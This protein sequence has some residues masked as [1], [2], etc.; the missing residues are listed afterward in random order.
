L[1]TQA[2]FETAILKIIF[3]G[4]TISSSWGNG[5]ATPCRAILRSLHA[6]GHQVAFYEKELDYYARRRDFASCSYCN[7][8]LYPEWGQIREQAL[9]DI[10]SADVVIVTS[11]CPEGARISDELLNLHRPLRVFYDLDTPITLE[12]LRHDGVDY[13]RADQIAE[14]DLY[15]S[16]AGGPILGELKQDWGARCARA[17]FGCVEPSLY[18]RVPPR[19]SF[20]SQLSYMGTYSPDRQAKVEALF[21]EPARSQTQSKFLLAG[22][23]Y[24]AGVSWPENVRLLEHIAPADH[25]A[26]YSSSRL[27]LNLTRSGMARYGFCPSGRFFEAAACGTPLVSDSFPGLGSFFVPD[28]EL[29]LVHDA[30]GVVQAMACSDEE[31]ARMAVRARE[32]TLSEH[33]GD[34]R[35]RQLVAFCEEARGATH[36]NEVKD[37]A[38]MIPELPGLPESD[39]VSDPSTLTGGAS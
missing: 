8:V 24:P 15:L 34:R 17:L 38:R 26:L 35:A 30:H 18:R 27:T 14:F 16:F 25:P 20:Q 13:L 22:S 10:A 2:E 11:Y 31:L 39:R 5:H 19:P 9:R 1:R 6:L 37:R 12:N 28:E 23:M 32:R 3:L 21:L 33:S 36:G 7:L 29:F 4:L